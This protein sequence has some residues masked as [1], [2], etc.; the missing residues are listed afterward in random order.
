MHKLI[1]CV[2]NADA[3]AVMVKPDALFRHKIIYEADRKDLFVCCDIFFQLGF[4]ICFFRFFIGF[5]KHKAPVAHLAFYA[6]H[7]KKLSIFI[8]RNPFAALKVNRIRHLAYFNRKGKRF[9]FI[10]FY[11]RSETPGSV[12]LYFCAVIAEGTFSD[13]KRYNFT[14]FSEEERRLFAIIENR[15]RYISAKLNAAFT[16]FESRQ[17]KLNT[18]CFI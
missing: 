4:F 18:V 8:E 6:V 16:G 7:N 13:F 5:F 12:I 3:L 9:T 11:D 2:V 10:D 1:I 15:R 17:H 14:P